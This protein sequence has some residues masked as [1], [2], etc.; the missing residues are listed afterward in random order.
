MATKRFRR[1]NIVVLKN[2]D[3]MEISDHQQMAGLLSSSYKERMGHSYVI[4]MQFYLS[5]LLDKVEG[6]DEPTIPF[7]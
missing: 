3:G 2:E 5:T 6:L 4:Y 7:E 1:N